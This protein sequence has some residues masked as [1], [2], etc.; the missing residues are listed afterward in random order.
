[1]H[2]REGEHV[3]TRRGAAVEHAPDGVVVARLEL[4]EPT[5]KPRGLDARVAQCA[6]HAGLLLGQRAVGGHYQC[7]RVAHVVRLPLERRRACQ[8]RE[9]FDVEH[10]RGCRQDALRQG[11][12]APELRGLDDVEP[13][14]RRP[15]RVVGRAVAG[16]HRRDERVD[17]RG[18]GP[19]AVQLLRAAGAVRPADAEHVGVVPDP[20]E[21][22]DAVPGRGEVP[23]AGP[24]GGGAEGEQLPV[25]VVVV[26]ARRGRWGLGEAEPARVED[27]DAVR[28]ELQ[29]GGPGDGV[30]RRGPVAV[31]RGAVCGGRRV[32]PA[33]NPDVEAPPDRARALGRGRVPVEYDVS[34]VNSCHC[35]CPRFPSSVQQ[36]HAAQLKSQSQSESPHLL[37]IIFFFLSR[38]GPTAYLTAHGLR[39]FFS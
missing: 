25:V 4:A 21:A 11:P 22:G 6:Q 16:R 15:G 10:G 35:F 27:A 5:R 8:A 1:M 31:R 29:Q 2:G 3:P 37:S 7:P 13:A 14:R 28:R 12:A 32:P 17:D 23:A 30:L 9:A 18:H 26:C 19:G 24:R 34:L 20:F 38:N 33:G 36:Q 39:C